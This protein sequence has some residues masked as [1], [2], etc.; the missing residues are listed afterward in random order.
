MRPV[1]QKTFSVSWLA[2]LRWSFGGYVTGTLLAAGAG[3][4]D[5]PL[6]AQVMLLAAAVCFAASLV[7]AG[8]CFRGSKDCPVVLASCPRDDYGCGSV[9]EW[10]RLI[11]HLYI[12]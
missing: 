3:A 8:A 10:R 11:S 2:G 4:L 12:F 7:C 9:W 1:R 6:L 5:F